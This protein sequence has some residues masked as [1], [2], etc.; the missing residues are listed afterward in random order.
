MSKQPQVFA[1]GLAHLFRDRGEA[2]LGNISVGI[3]G[4]DAATA[5]KAA[6]VTKGFKFPAGVS[7]S[8]GTIPAGTQVSSSHAAAGPSSSSSIEL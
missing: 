1:G 7:C 8:S 3:A 4:L 2:G 6:Q 5:A